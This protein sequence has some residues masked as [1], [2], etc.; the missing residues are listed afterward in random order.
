MQHFKWTSLETGDEISF[1]GKVSNLTARSVSSAL[2]A[3]LIRSTPRLICFHE[4]HRQRKARSDNM[5][6]SE[7]DT[8]QTTVLGVV[9]STHR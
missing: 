9:I 7:N 8:Y 2:H 6:W 1:V 5:T 4:A 3:N